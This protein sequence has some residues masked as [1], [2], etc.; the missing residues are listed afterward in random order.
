MDKGVFDR[1]FKNSGIWVRSNPDKWTVIFKNLPP[2]EHNT[3]L[4]GGSNRFSDG[5]RRLWKF[6]KRNNHPLVEKGIAFWTDEKTLITG[7][8]LNSNR[9][10][11]RPIFQYKVEELKC[12]LRIDINYYVKF[13]VADKRQEM[14]KKILMNTIKLNILPEEIIDKICQLTYDPYLLM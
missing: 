2:E 6:G 14:Y 10:I 9:N 11:Y 4:L 1:K 8:T 13:I 12:K 5:E 7:Y 3:W